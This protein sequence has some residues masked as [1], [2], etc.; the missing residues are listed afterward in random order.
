M[1]LRIR[2]PCRRPC[3]GLPRSSVLR[4]LPAMDLRGDSN[5][6]SSALLAV[7]RRVAPAFTACC[8]LDAS[9]GFPL[10]LHLPALPATHLR[11]DSKVA[12]FGGADGTFPGFPV[13]RSF[14]IAEDQFRVAPQLH[15]PAPS[16][17]SAESPRPLHPPASP[18]RISGSPR[19][20]FALWLLRRSWPQFR[21]GASVLRR[22]R[23][24]DPRFAPIRC[25]SAD[26]PCFPQVAPA[27]H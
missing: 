12:P 17:E 24:T 18:E 3:F 23:L 20:F 22:R 10:F 5:P 2:W 26:R 6:H 1:R 13:P 11:G 8:A 14:G 19:I 16:D 27:S 9:F 7:M 15:P 25:P 4:L 21:P